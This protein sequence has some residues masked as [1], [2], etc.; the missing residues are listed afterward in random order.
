MRLPYFHHLP[1]S[2]IAVAFSFPGALKPERMDVR[3]SSSDL[4]KGEQ[5]APIKSVLFTD[6]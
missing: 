4:Q 3:L 2:Q 5:L 1:C 6:L